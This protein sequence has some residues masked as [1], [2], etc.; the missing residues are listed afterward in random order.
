MSRLRI[1]LFGLLGQGNLG[2]DGSLLAVLTDLR[3][4]HPDAELD[5]FCYSRPCA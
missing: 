1:G 2:N 3:S 4:R 5:F